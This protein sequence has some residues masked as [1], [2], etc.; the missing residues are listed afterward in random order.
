[1]QFQDEPDVTNLPLI[2]L[3]EENPLNNSLESSGSDLQ[4]SFDTPFQNLHPKYL[5]YL[6]IIYQWCRTV[7]LWILSLAFAAFTDD[8]GDFREICKGFGFIFLLGFILG[9]SV[10][11]NTNQFNTD[12]YPYLSSILGYTYF[13]AW[14]I[15]WYPQLILNM[16]RRTTEGLSVD[17]VTLNVLGFAAYATFNSAFFWSDKIKEEYR[18]THDGQEN[19]IQS[20]DVAFSLHAI[21][22]SSITLCQIGYYDGFRQRPPAKLTIAFVGIAIVISYVY[23]LLIESQKKEDVEQHPRLTWMN[24]LYWLSYLKLAITTIKYCPQAFLNY[25]RKSTIGWNIWGVILDFSGGILSLMQLVL[26]CWNLGD[27]SGITGDIPKFL[28]S[29][30]SISFNVSVDL[31]TCLRLSAL[32]TFFG[33][34]WHIRSYIV[35]YLK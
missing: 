13:V 22:M 30:L 25:S 32:H 27:F 31:L 29:W 23:A 4:H 20:N 14:S 11:P 33:K 21:L 34:M 3:H 17:L 19:L 1:M 6:E 15:S 24:F 10:P 2:S 7:F 9:I 18:G 8:S 12:W 26:D 5:F 16:K 35:K 28:L